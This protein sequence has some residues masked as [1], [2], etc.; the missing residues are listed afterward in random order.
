MTTLNDRL[1]LDCMP[2]EVHADGSITSTTGIYAP[3]VYDENVHPDGL[4][5]H[6]DPDDWEFLNGYSG[7]DRYSGPVMHASESIGG[8]LERDILDTPGIYVAVVVE[9]LTDPD[10]PDRTEDIEPAGWAVLRR[11]EQP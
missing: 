6:V 10:D 9:C 1:G 4:A 5:T 3:E 8:R 2:I 7:Q 11:K